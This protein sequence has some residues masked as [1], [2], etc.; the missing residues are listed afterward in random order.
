MARY[1]DSKCRL[2]RREGTKL[3]L[4]GERCFSPKCPLEKKGAVAPG[5]HG[6]KMRRRLSEYGVQLREKQK[7]KRTYGVLERQ[8]RRYF[9]KA[10]KKR[11]VT[12]EALLQLLESR[13][14][15]VVY[16]LGFVPSRSV[17]RQLVRHGHILVDGK[18]VDIPSYQVKPGQV[19]NLNPKA[20]KMEVVKKSLAE[21]KK[22]IPSWLQ[23]KAAVGKI[24]RLPTREEIGADIAEQLIVEYY[25]R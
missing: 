8:F 11:G 17:A 15:N 19:I 22:E 2:C 5:Q 3:F 10:F 25:S 16:R 14:D 18:K 13:L 9:K 20:M 24:I 1:L 7:A 21:K 4:K 6:L 12:G 23:K